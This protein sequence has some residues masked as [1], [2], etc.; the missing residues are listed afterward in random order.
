MLFSRWWPSE[1]DSVLNPPA[2]AERNENWSIEAMLGRYDSS[3][4]TITVYTKGV[5]LVAGWLGVPEERL[6]YIVR[7]HEWGHAVLHL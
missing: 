4:Q 7:I 1:E 2:W 3:L 5:E 6:K